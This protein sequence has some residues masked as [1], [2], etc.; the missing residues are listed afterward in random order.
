MKTV[1]T[2]ILCEDHEYDMH[3]CM[4]H[5]LPAYAVTNICLHCG[6]FSGICTYKVRFI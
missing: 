6:L 3:P 1:R 5:H 2:L 4:L